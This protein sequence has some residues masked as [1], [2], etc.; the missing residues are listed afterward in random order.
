MFLA[1]LN[2]AALMEFAQYFSAGRS[3]MLIDFSGGLMRSLGGAVLGPIIN[4]A[5]YPD[6]PKG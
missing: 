4:R 1:Q 2:L 6:D 3:P 5:R